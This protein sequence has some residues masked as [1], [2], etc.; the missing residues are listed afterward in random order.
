MFEFKFHISI[1]D[2]NFWSCYFS[3]KAGFCPSETQGSFQEEETG[4]RAEATAGTDCFGGEVHRNPP[5]P[6]NPVV[7]GSLKQ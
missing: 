2:L 3:Y 6:E 7:W 5:G 4:M 1:W